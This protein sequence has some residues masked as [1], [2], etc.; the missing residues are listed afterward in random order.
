MF[1]FVG[2]NQ[3]LVIGFGHVDGFVE[4]FEHSL[5]DGVHLGMKFDV[6]H[7]VAQ[8]EDGGIGIFPEY[9]RGTQHF[10]REQR[11][12]TGNSQ[13]GFGGYIVIIFFTFLYGVEAGDSCLQHIVN[14]W[15]R[16]F[17]CFFHGLY[18]VGNAYGI[19][20]LER[21]EF[22]AKT[23][24]HGIIYLVQVAGDFRNSVGDKLEQTVKRTTVKFT[25]FSFVRHE[26]GHPLAKIID[27]FGFFEYGEFGTWRLHIIQGGKI[28][29]EEFFLTPFVNFFKEPLLCF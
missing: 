13:I 18:S 5:A 23:C 15:C 11:F 22:P 3:G 9:V 17:A 26:D 21:P 14:P 4:S 29:I 8:I 16:F 2:Y 6:Q 19:P 1:A 25:C 12:L 24:I 20:G 28:Q 27:A 7:P 10:K